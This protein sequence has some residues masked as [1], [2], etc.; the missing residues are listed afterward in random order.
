M[1]F[2]KYHDS[3]KDKIELSTE[4]TLRTD[5]EILINAIK[6]RK[7]VEIIQE[8]KKTETQT[9]GK[10]DFKVTE[11]ELEIG[12]IETKPFNDDLSVYVDT[13]QLKRYLNVIPNL[14][15]TNYRDFILF[16]DGE[17]I[18]N[19]TLLIKGEKKL[20]DSNIEKTKIVIN[21]FFDGKF[22]QIEKTE[23]L[24]ILLAKHAQYLHDEILDLWNSNEKSQ[25]KEKLCGLY[26]LFSKTLIEELK[27]S[28]FIDAYAQTVTYG[29]LLSALSANKIG[30]A[31][32]R[33]RV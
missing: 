1:E 32:C 27:P 19:S 5:F 28:D 14:L 6:P 26:D 29:L 18:L 15:F 30:R 4:Y 17:P 16:R 9:F 33:E 2:K 8:N 10:P 13:P 20:Q 31:S 25:F 22:Q 7:S 11:N 12:W 24:S 23:K 3:I 21:E